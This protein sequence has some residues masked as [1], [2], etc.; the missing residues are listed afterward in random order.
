[1]EQCRLDFITKNYQKMSCKELAVEYNK[2][3]GTSISDC[4]IRQLK[5]RYKL[6]T[7]NKDTTKFKKGN[8]I[9]RKPIGSEWKKT[10]SGD[11]YIKVANPDVWVLK[12]KYVYEQ[13]YG[14]LDD[15][16][17][18]ICLDGNKE[19]ID[20]NNLLAI[21]RKD[22]LFLNMYKLSRSPE[23]IKTGILISKIAYKRLELEKNR[24][25]VK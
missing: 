9:S 3:F 24:S 17:E 10:S 1:M 12:K 23:I 5:K 8:T 25:D 14:K 11:I 4:A 2:K 7:P 6:P 19:N 16:Y 20:I 22:L 13:H 18:I 15:N 21:R